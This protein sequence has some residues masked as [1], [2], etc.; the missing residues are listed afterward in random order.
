MK[1]TAEDGTLF[2]TEKECLDYEKK[3]KEEKMKEIIGDFIAYNEDIEYSSFADSCFIPKYI[4]I[5]SN[6]E[7]VVNYIDKY[8]NYYADGIN[9]NDIY[10]YDKDEYEWITITDLIAKHEEAIKSLVDVK[11]KILRDNYN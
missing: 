2:S 6:F 11:N 3:L 7:K 9:S 8:T 4:Y 1:Y 10:M 5:F